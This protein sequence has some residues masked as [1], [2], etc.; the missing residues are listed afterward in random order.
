MKW[1]GNGKLWHS[2]SSSSIFHRK[3]ES[4]LPCGQPSTVTVTLEARGLGSV[5]EREFRKFARSFTSKAGQFLL[6]RQFRIAGCQAASK[7]DL[8]SRNAQQV[9]TLFFLLFS[10]RLVRERVAVSVEKPDL[11]PCWFGLNQLLAEPKRFNLTRIIFSN[12]LERA[13]RILM[14]LK[15]LGWL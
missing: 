10:I 3:G 2:R 13:L 8:I 14:G 15:L 1:K 4:T 6:I 5:Q 11:K 9:V 12:S 7:P